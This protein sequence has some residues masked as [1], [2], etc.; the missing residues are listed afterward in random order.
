MSRINYNRFVEDSDFLN[1][2]GMTEKNSLI[3]FFNQTG[4]RKM[5]TVNLVS[6]L[7]CP[8]AEKS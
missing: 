7:D 3:I 5:S 4:C 6:G 2:F 8:L 1:C